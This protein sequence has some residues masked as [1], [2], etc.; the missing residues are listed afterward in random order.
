MPKV[1]VVMPAYN[2]ENTQYRKEEYCTRMFVSD[3]V[4]QIGH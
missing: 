1:S 2:A 3:I 4:C